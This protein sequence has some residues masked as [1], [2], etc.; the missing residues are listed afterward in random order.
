M[1][2]EEIRHANMHG[3]YLWGDFLKL[4]L[5]PPPDLKLM[6]LETAMTTSIDNDDI[7]WEKGIN[8]HFH[9]DNFKGVME[10]YQ[11]ACHAYRKEHGADD[12]NGQETKED[13]AKIFAGHPIR[14][15]SVSRWQTITL[16]TL[17]DKL[18]PWRLFHF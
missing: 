16:W 4:T 9:L 12:N 5:N 6:N 13:A 1:S 18:L 17:E 15:R 3:S 8:Y 10:G 14:V 2:L 11:T 7:P